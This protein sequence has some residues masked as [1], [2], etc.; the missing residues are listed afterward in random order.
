MSRE[1]MHGRLI[2]R[3]WSSVTSLIFFLNRT[4]R[5]SKRVEDRLIVDGQALHL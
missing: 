4:Y 1:Q 3:G 5:E 2:N